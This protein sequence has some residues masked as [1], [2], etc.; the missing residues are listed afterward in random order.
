MAAS[1]NDD[2]LDLIDCLAAEAVEYVVVGAFALAIHGLPRATGDIDILVRPSAANAP[3]V[4]RAL[5]R[6]GA[7]LDGAGVSEADFTVP[8][9]V[10]QLGLAPRRIDILT[11]ISGVSFD[12]AW[13]TRHQR[14][15]DGRSIGFLGEAELIRNK[16][17]TGRPKDVV[18][19]DALERL[20]RG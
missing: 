17:A 15:V 8:G 20:R 3:R 10:Y 19:A 6:F 11:A 13:A 5:I 7:P 2:Y 4:I 18:D 12:E 1:W 9:V 16:R 14:L